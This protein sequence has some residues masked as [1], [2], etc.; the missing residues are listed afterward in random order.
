MN[1]RSDEEYI[2]T[3]P[4]F[5]DE[6]DLTCRN[7]TIR[8]ARKAHVCY[9]LGGRRDHSIQPGERYR[10][11]RAR[12]DDSF[13]GEYKICLRCMAKF[14]DDDFGDDDDDGKGQDSAKESAEGSGK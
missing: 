4:F 10:F 14:I 2:G 13:W 5:G 1:Q 8:T 3:D 6:S 12:V 9:G 11:E 7:V